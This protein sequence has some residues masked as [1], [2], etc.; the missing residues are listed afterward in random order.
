MVA[1]PA[2]LFDVVMKGAG[3]AYS[4]AELVSLWECSL[5]MLADNLLTGV[6]IGSD[7][8][9]SEIVNYGHTGTANAS[10]PISI[11]RFEAFAVPV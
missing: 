2:E 9:V 10:Q 6:G 8:F 1:L 11:K 7:S 3:F 4:K 5:S